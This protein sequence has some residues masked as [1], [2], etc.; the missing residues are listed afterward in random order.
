MRSQQAN[1]ERRIMA[2]LQFDVTQC[3][4][5]D[6]IP[7]DAISHDRV[8][9]D[10]NFFVRFRDCD[11]RMC[12]AK[13]EAEAHGRCIHAHAEFRGWPWVHA[14][15]RESALKT[16]IVGLSSRSKGQI[17]AT[18]QRCFLVKH[19]CLCNALFTLQRFQLF[20]VVH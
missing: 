16:R 9:Y 12:R 1:K 19:K 17:L 10:P 2:S 20:L 7:S 11:R 4:T 14:L 8:S 15:L 3:L 18:F 5:Q 13:S 6:V